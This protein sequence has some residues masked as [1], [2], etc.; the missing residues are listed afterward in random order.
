MR[1]DK[2]RHILIKEQLQRHQR[3][4]QTRLEHAALKNLLVDPVSF[5]DGV[6]KAIIRILLLWRHIRHIDIKSTPVGVAVRMWHRQD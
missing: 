4:C 2:Q 1:V 5:V 6:D 3:F